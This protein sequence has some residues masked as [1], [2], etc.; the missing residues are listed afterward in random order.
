MLDHSIQ[1]IHALA[2]VAFRVEIFPVL[3]FVQSH[4]TFQP[5][6]TPGVSK[7]E[8]NLREGRCVMVGPSKPA[9]AKIDKTV[10]RAEP[11]FQFIS[12]PSSP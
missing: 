2:P 8:S 11:V 12:S 4:F 5:P 7:E 9:E 6:Q 1:A 10:V 3:R